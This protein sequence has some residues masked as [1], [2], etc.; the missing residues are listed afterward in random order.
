MVSSVS[1]APG[2]G[3]LTSVG[4]EL[5]ALLAPSEG[6][7]ALHAAKSD[8]D[9]RID[10]L[11]GLA[12]VVIFVD[13]IPRNPLSAFTP[14]AMGL[15]DAA[16]AFV[17]MSG[18]VC[19]LVYSRVLV[20]KGWATVWHKVLK[21]CG[22]LYFANLLMLAA[23]VAVAGFWHGRGPGG[24]EYDRFFT[25]TPA[26]VR[27]A[28]MLRF[29]P[30]L[31]QVLNLYL[32]MLL[33]LPVG[34]WLLHSR[35]GWRAMMGVSL[36]IYVAAQC[37]W[38]SLPTTRGLWNFNPLAWQLLFFMGVALGGRRG[39]RE[40]SWRSAVSDPQGRRLAWAAAAA[41]LMILAA[42]HVEPVP[43]SSGLRASLNVCGDR[44]IPYSDKGMLGPLR[45]A[46]FL[47]VAYVCG[48]LIPRRAAFFGGAMGRALVITGRHSL[49][50]FCLGGVLSYAAGFVAD[51]A[52]LTM[53]VFVVLNAWGALALMLTAQ[54]LEARRGV[55][56]VVVG[57]R[58]V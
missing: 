13:H 32:I 9:L 41:L 50:V 49:P 57:V 15:S 51:R 17:F 39:G 7:R 31:V 21:R 2:S 53:L 52:G 47:L 3:A 43:G 54:G 12:L 1:L 34:L 18:L 11:R 29:A 56:R 6:G 23:C 37:S 26:A 24:A 27:D 38:I 19:G 58:G 48:T 46:H 5:A 4:S 10:F 28:L 36:G 16:E 45:A 8:R 33:V 42:M 44:M 55:A 35:G 20:A 30:G 40:E 25:D 14:Q 22:Q